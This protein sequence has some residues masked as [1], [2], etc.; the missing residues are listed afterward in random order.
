MAKHPSYTVY[1]CLSASYFI[2]HTIQCEN[3]SCARLNRI[4]DY[5]KKIGNVSSTRSFISAECTVQ[6]WVG[7]GLYRVLVTRLF[8]LLVRNWILYR[9]QGY[10]LPCQIN[11]VFFSCTPFFLFEQ[12][13][14]DMTSW[15][16]RIF[17]SLGYQT[18]PDDDNTFLCDECEFCTTLYL[19]LRVMTSANS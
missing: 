10:F 15:T 19:N 6:L 16:T 2:V 18:S 12:H 4:S 3:T 13:N 17:L 1:L 14:N 11:Q 9:I 8:V 7:A 5:I